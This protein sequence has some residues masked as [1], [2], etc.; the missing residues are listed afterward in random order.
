M[1]IKG[2]LFDLY[3][4]LIDIETDESM[5]EIYRGIAHFLTYHGVYL[6]RGEVRDL[7]YRIM[8]EQRERSREEHPEIIVKAI[9]SE[10]LQEQGVKPGQERVRLATTLAQIYRA[11]SRKRLSLFPGVKEVLDLLHASYPLALVSDAQPCY[12]HP[13][14]RAVG[15]EGYFDPI[16]ISADYGFRK[17]DRRLFQTALDDLELRPDEAVFVGNDMHRDIYGASR[18]GIKTVFFSSNQGAQSYQDAN[19]TRVITRFEQVPEVVAELSSKGKEP[20]A[21]ARGFF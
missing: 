7:Y 18:T 12:V 6:H 1:T 14:I 17:P 2:I 4:T 20:R 16:V 19:P 8:Q 5:E 15:L 13:E 10:F 21:P 3:G 11:I 9:W